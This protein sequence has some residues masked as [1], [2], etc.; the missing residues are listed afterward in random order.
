MLCDLHKLHVLKILGTP[1]WAEKSACGSQK[2]LSKLILDR[3]K[4]LDE[5]DETFLRQLQNVSEAFHPLD[6]A[7]HL[8]IQQYGGGLRRPPT[9]VD[10]IMLDGK[11][12]G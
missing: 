11:M 8:P 9:V 10:S 6:L 3:G 7:I 4:W 12:N 1:L 2:D 5:V